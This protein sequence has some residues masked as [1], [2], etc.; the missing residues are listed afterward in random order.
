MAA[1]VPVTPMNDGSKKADVPRELLPA[2]RAPGPRATSTTALVAAGRSASC[3]CARG[4]QRER[5]RADVGAAREAEE[6]QRPASAQPRRIEA[7]AV[8][9]RRASTGGIV[10]GALRQHRVA[11]GV[12]RRSATSEPRDLHAHRVRRA[13]P[14]AAMTRIGSVA[15]PSPELSHTRRDGLASRTTDARARLPRP[16][17][18]P[19]D[20]LTRMPPFRRPRR[21]RL[22]RTGRRGASTRARSAYGHGTDNAHG[23]GCGARLP[24]ARAGRTRTRRPLR[25]GPSPRAGAPSGW[26]GSSSGASA[27]GCRRPTSRAAPGSR[28][29]RCAST[30]GVLVPRSPIAELCRAR[31]RAVGRSARACGASLDIGTGSGCIA[32]ACA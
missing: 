7:R 23:R 19:R 17:C 12:A 15:G 16:A 2:C 3:A 26:R 8:V 18:V 10:R 24:R 31:L 27:S 22:R 30:P 1:R 20:F 9:R 32:I 13:G 21:P 14:A 28:G 5:R 29:S 25:A 11:C 6:H 4:E